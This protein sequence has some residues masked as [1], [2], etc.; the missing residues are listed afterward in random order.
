MKVML[1]AGDA[2]LL[3]DVQKDFLPGGNLPVPGGG[4]IV[5]VLNRYLA[6]FHAHDLP[7]LATR[8]WHPPDHCS[9][10]RNGG[11]WPP[12]CIAGTPGAAFPVGLELPSHAHIISK[13]TSSEKDAYSGFDGTQLD[14]LL[15]SSGIQRLFIGGVATEHCVLNTVRDALRYGYPSFVLEDAVSAISIPDG[16]DTLEEMVRLGAIPIRYETLA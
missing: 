14:A 10:L 8:D 12:H 11:I 3:V 5:P 4:E 6:L 16:L 13:A 1:T 15:R 2:L 7:V 9:F